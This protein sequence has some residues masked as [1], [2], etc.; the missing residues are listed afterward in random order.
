MHSNTG[1]NNKYDILLQILR[2]FKK[3]AD[4][5][6]VLQSQDESKIP[7]SKVPFY[8]DK[9]LEKHLELDDYLGDKG[10]NV[11]NSQ[12][13]SA[14][15]KIQ[16]A[17]HKGES[18]IRLSEEEKDAVTISKKED[19]EGGSCS[20]SEVDERLIQSI[21]EEYDMQVLKK[22]KTEFPCKSTD[23]CVSTSVIVETLFSGCGVIM[24]PHR[25]CMDPNTLERLFFYV[26]IKTFGRGASRSSNKIQS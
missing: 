15:V 16:R 18:S 1:T 6:V 20:E 4:V 26:P 8:F 25:R 10:R 12:F 21:N 23:H 3:F 5:T 22:A 2:E 19:E 11:H 13:E 9:I 7:L 24:R 17:A 14:V